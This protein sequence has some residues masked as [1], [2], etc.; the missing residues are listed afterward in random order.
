MKDQV[1]LGGQLISYSKF[2]QAG[3]GRQMVF[4]HGWRSSKEVWQSMIK[5]L[6]LKLKDWE[7][8]ALDLPG[9]GQS[10]A[11]KSAWNVN[12]YA[13]LVGEFIQKLNLNNVTLVGHSFGG[14][15]A[16]RLSAL[17]P[18]LV[19]KLVLLDA[20]GFAMEKN[21]KAAIKIAAKIV[22]PIF[23]PKFMQGLRKKIYQKIGAEDYL[24]TP[25]LQKTF[26]NVVEED[27]TESLKR[28]LQ[29]TLIVFGENDADTPVATAE[30][31][32]GLV[33]NS[34]LMVLK[35]AGHF[36][37][38]DQPAELIKVLSDFV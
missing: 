23:K 11:P 38:L 24:A 19:K 21:K 14:R 37:F 8:F 2:G 34:R 28:I 5:D 18:N 6:G 20:A 17:R 16:I 3:A 9:F 15:A 25:E 1:V 27:L 36:S 7:F 22:K 32:K 33:A 13:N 31:M 4:L 26:I 29:P 10:P 35:D 12:D 30:K